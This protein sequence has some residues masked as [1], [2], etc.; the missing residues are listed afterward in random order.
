MAPGRLAPFC[1][2]WYARVGEPQ[3]PT[4]NAAGLPMVTLRLWGWL[5]I[6]GKA[7]TEIVP[8]LA[9]LEASQSKLVA[10]GGRVMAEK[11]PA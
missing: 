3:A 2:H 6:V 7:A 10:R 1:C 8:L 9:I 5:V 11:T 4:L